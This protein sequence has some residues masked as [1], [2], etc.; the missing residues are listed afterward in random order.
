[1]KALLVLAFSALCAFQSSPAQIGWTREK[2]QSVY[3]EPV[4]S[5]HRESASYVQYYTP[6][7]ILNLYFNGDIAKDPTA[8]VTKANFQTISIVQAGGF[9]PVAIADIQYLMEQNSMGH[10]WTAQQY[11]VKRSNGLQYMGFMTEHKKG[12]DFVMAA[13]MDWNATGYYSGVE[14]V[15]FPAISLSS[16]GHSP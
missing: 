5:W 14:I 11:L 12:E 4:S 7:W 3:G 2:C 16:A 9:H 10:T 1:M 8:I 13:P 6:F 15:Y